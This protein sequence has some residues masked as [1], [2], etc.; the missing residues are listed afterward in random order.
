MGQLTA[1]TITIG[2]EVPVALLWLLAW[3]WLQRDQLRRAAVV[4][5]AASLLTHPVA[6]WASHYGLPDWPWENKVVAIEG[7]V[8]AV[9]AVIVA[10][11]MPMSGRR[12]VV[13]AAVANAASFAVGWAL[14]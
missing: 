13:V 8:I 6:W 14:I 9:E 3:R 4:V 5:A 7:T 10:L 11:A 12:A 2:V 1:L